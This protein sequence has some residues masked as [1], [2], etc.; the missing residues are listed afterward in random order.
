VDQALLSQ[1]LRHVFVVEDDLAV[2]EALVML[3]EGQGWSCRAFE[4]GE[5]FLDIAR[6]GQDDVLILDLDLPGMNG[7]DIAATLRARGVSPSIY[8]VSGLRNRAFEAG[9]ASIKP[10][11]AF[12][13]PLDTQGLLDAVTVLQ[14]PS[15]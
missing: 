4:S 12:R 13:K 7:T 11:A 15:A 8:V 1:P 14:P 6:P 2:R 9:V 3:V 10:V 5:R